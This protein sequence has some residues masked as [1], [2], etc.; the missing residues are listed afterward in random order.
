[1]TAYTT[2]LV[3]DET[4]FAG[5]AAEWGGL[6][7][8]C[9]TATPFQSHA[10]LWS[11]WQS[12]GRP[13][14]L[15]LLLVRAGGTA[16][17]AAGGAARG[18]LVAAAPLTVVRRPLP[19]LVPLGGAISDYGDVLIDDEHGEPAAAALTGALAAAA[20]TVLIDLREVRPGAAAERIYDRWAGPRRRLADSVCLELPAVP[21]DGLV[22]RLPSAKA[23]QRVRAKLRKLDAL[24]VERRT[25][26]ADEADK[27]L[28]RLLELHRLQWQGRGV[29]GEHLQERFQ[30]HL[31]RAAGEM[32]RS[33][34]AAVTEF[35]LEDD[36]VAVDLTLLAP[37][38]IGGYLYGAHPCLR[39]R[40]VDVAVMLLD[41]CTERLAGGGHTTLSLLRGEEPYKHH[42]RPETVPN[43]R[44]L[45]ARRRTA[46]LLAAALGRATAR[47]RGKELLRR[48]N[49]RKDGRG[50]GGT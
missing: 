45:L 22:S 25:V 20:G 19:A 32:V 35:R 14:R 29:T 13:G 11:W 43:A 23:Q 26:H 12:Y 48:R 21:M 42:W 36:V 34:D 5:L 6:Y 10:W 7:R 16:G 39:E 30:E 4:E 3:T 37:R 40:R 24:G 50:G 2:R 44:L 46:P 47:R 33:G 8:R 9:G 15:R 41:A 1:M 38:L 31:V 27:A 18:E 17:A 28:R 49:D